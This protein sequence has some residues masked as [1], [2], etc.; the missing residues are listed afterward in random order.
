M[1]LVEY[2]LI[3][4]IILMIANFMFWASSPAD[5]MQFQTVLQISEDI[6]ELNRKLDAI[7]LELSIK[8]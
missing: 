4:I 5:K 2:L 1:G 8:D 7:E 6:Q 3:T